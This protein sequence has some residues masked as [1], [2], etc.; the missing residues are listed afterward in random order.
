MKLK[1][2]EEIE[3]QRRDEIVSELKADLKA[4]QEE[5]RPYE[6]SWLLNIN[7]LIGNQNSYISSRGAIDEHG[8]LFPWESREVFN[9]I[10]PIIESR[11]AKLSRVRPSMTVMPTGSEQSD[12]EVAKL[13]K[14]ILDCVASE[15]N[16]SKIVS[17]ATIWSEVTGTAFYKIFWNEN[18][19]VMIDKDNLIN[20]NSPN[21]DILSKKFDEISRKLQ[22]NS[23]KNITM[24][25]AEIV[26]V[27]PFEIFPDSCATAS[28]DE[29]ESIIHAYPISVSDAERLYDMPFVGEDIS[30]MSLDAK[31]D[32]YFSSGASNVFK[33]VSG[34][35]HNQVLVIEKYIRPTSSQ[36]N[37]RLIIVAGDELVFDGELPLLIYP[38]V[39]QV[40]EET[41]GSFFGTSVIER[42]IPIQRLYNGIKNRKYEFFSRLSAGVLAV[43][44]GSVD[45]DSL[46]EEGLAPGKILVYRSGSSVP[47]FM[48]A[49]DIPNEFNQEEDR[50]I[51][52]FISITGVSELMR[53]STL[54]NNV[55]SGT[56]INLLIEQ[57]D[58][59]LSISAENIRQAFTKIGK[60]ILSLYKNFAEFPKISK[61]I[62]DN[63]DIQ[64][65]Y[66][67]KS[68][69]SSCDVVLETTNELS[70][71]PTVRRNMILELLKNGLLYDENGKLSNRMKSKIYEALGFGNFEASQD[72]IALHIKKANK[73]N[74]GLS[75]LI[76][77]EID[78]H[79]I[80]IEEH[81]KFLLSDES[82][83][84]TEEERDKYI[85]HIREHGMFRRL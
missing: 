65:F 12:I 54:P 29:C 79:D 2:D 69:I 60:M 37:G 36:P 34:V 23:N 32:P 19:G 43:E 85:N 67:D 13:S 18:A 46:E 45:I 75:P 33:T 72:I 17:D 84:L 61:I 5:R 42:C 62:D 80:H 51:N 78:D 4:R 16:L 70:E 82:Q 22:K 64:L 71:T 26:A 11:L 30:V 73:E 77:S 40:S 48:D 83:K 8:R 50:L 66:W 41:I 68:D 39:K 15:K 38:F 81:K 55:T 31:M 21:Y 76:V 24:G 25:D 3:K 74:L 9:H 6:L 1:S 53:N 44:D 59:R 14:S 47:K 58:T 35:K 7:F 49:G 56:A 20:K 10:A 63:G 52:E 57:D 27:S 28:V